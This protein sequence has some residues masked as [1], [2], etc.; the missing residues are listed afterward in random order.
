MRRRIA[1]LLQDTVKLVDE[2]IRTLEIAKDTSHLKYALAPEEF[3]A[4]ER[5][6][7]KLEEL[8]LAIE[9]ELHLR[10]PTLAAQWTGGSQTSARDPSEEAAGT[11]LHVRRA[12]EDRAEGSFA[13]SA[14][15]SPLKPGAPEASVGKSFKDAEDVPT[16]TPSTLEV[17]VGRFF[18]EASDNPDE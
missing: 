18:Q 8:A 1:R 10:Q 2:S 15:T 6:Q 12:L 3:A 11:T 9:F 5:V 17:R 14:N 7:A 4:I 16:H 13:E